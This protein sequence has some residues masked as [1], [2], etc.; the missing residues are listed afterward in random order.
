MLLQ[1]RQLA[2]AFCHPSAR[3]L[4]RTQV[5]QQAQPELV[6]AVSAAAARYGHVMFPENAHEPAVEVSP[7]C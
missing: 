6:R 3:L 4:A 1:H 7:G 5:S 2:A